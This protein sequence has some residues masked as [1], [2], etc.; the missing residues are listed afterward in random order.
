MAQRTSG[1]GDIHCNHF[2]LLKLIYKYIPLFHIKVICFQH[3]SLSIIADIKIVRIVSR[4]DVHLFC[5]Q[6]SALVDMPSADTIR[7][8]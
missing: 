1:I 8:T 4:L 5:L 3:T 2:Y 7:Y 6:I